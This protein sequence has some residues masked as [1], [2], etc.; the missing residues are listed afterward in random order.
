M[1][2]CDEGFRR[3]CARSNLAPTARE[4][5]FSHHALSTSHLRPLTGQIC[6]GPDIERPLTGHKNP[7]F[8]QAY[9]KLNSTVRIRVSGFR[10]LNS[11]VRLRVLSVLELSRTVRFRVSGLDNPDSTVQFEEPDA[12]ASIILNEWRS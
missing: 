5:R 7:K 1:S 4:P 3:P 11:T 6:L 12:V 9:L 10:N 2:L 8:W